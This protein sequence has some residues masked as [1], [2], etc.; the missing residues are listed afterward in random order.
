MP[1]R[2]Y[3]QKLFDENSISS[4]K[5]PAEQLI[6]N[7]ERLDLLCSEYQTEGDALSGQLLLKESYT[8]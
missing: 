5:D 1:H 6:K 7:L 2:R 3:I 4:Y 8:S